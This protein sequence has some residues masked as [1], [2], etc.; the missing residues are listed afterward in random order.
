MNTFEGLPMRF[1]MEDV[2]IRRHSFAYACQGAKVLVALPS[3]AHEY[4]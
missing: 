4:P 1:L 3:P 2:V